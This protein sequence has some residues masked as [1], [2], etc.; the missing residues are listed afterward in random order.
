MSDC[1]PNMFVPV[2]QPAIFL[3]S[4]RLNYPLGVTLKAERARAEIC[5]VPCVEMLRTHIDER[6]APQ[7]DVTVA[8]MDDMTA[9]FGRML[10]DRLEE[11]G[12][13]EPLGYLM[14]VDMLILDCRIGVDA[15]TG[16]PMPEDYFYTDPRERRVD[17][18]YGMY[19]RQCDRMARAAFGDSFA[20][21]IDAYRR[22]AIAEVHAVGQ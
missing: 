16:E 12:H 4:T 11:Q 9:N 20:D 1:K 17:F 7:A 6:N 13:I 15:R 14:T 5:D 3:Y 8:R 21:E 2:A 22:A 18:I 19:Q 10:A